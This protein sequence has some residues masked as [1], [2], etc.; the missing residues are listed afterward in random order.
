MPEAAWPQTVAAATRDH[1]LGPGATRGNEKRRGRRWAVPV[2]AAA[3]VLGVV[4]G[5]M[6]ATSSGPVPP[7]LRPTGLAADLST[8]S[9]VAFRWSG[10]A[11]GPA[12]DQYEILQDGQVIG[13][14]PGNITYYRVAGLAPDASYQFQVMAIR[15][16]EHSPQSPVLRVNTL[17]PPLSAAVLDGNWTTSDRVISAVP[18]DPHFMKVG[19]TWTDTWAFTPACTVGPCSAKLTGYFYGWAFT[20]SLA[21]TGT[22]YT[23]TATLD[24]MNWCKSSTNYDRDTLHFQVQVQGARVRG[25]AWIAHSWTGTVTVDVP[26]NPV[27]NFNA[28]TFSVTVRD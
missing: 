7:V 23:G 4:I 25:Q 17:T 28:D 1:P 22:V 3:A 9:S 24:K 8:I 5:L 26:S 27:G 11:T 13:S 6:V 18:Y 16:G 15:G 2:V 10:P 20:S 19:T 12:P 21:S 14:V